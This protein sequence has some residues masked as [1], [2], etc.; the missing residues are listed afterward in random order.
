MG[1]PTKLIGLLSRRRDITLE[2]FAQHWRTIHR[3]LSLRLIPPGIMK[4]YVQNHR[5]PD[6]GSIPGL[7]LAGDGFPE[8]WTEGRDLLSKLASAPEYLEGAYLDEANFMD[9]RSQALLAREVVIDDGP[10][11]VAAPTFI[12]VM[13]FFRRRSGVALADVAQLAEDR[14]QPLLMPA[15]RP[16]RLTRH[17]ALE[18]P[19]DGGAT[20]EGVQNYDLIEASYWRSVN[21]FLTH[22][23]DHLAA[24]EPLN[25]SATIGVLVR[26][27]PVLFPVHITSK[28]ATT[29]A[30]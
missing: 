13:L 5:I 23:H 8:L 12:K 11:R 19:N 28:S 6:V 26:E 3:D 16:V 15:A 24:P 20:Y 1:E 4:G 21:E 2:A 7:P 22:W 29:V 18:L 27:E 30:L 9:R 10:G 17:I 14:R 25:D